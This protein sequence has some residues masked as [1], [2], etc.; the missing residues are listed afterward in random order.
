MML[1]VGAVVSCDENQVTVKFS[2]LTG[3]RLGMEEE[4]EE[5]EESHGWGDVVDRWRIITVS[6]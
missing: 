4:V 2:D 6:G 3:V 1:Y 5:I